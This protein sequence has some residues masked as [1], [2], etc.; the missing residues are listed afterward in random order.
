MESS[1]LGRGFN[2][3][4]PPS[5]VVKYNLPPELR[6]HVSDPVICDSVGIFTS[7]EIFRT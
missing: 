7:K 4:T 6:F 3:Q 1:I 2:F 5:F